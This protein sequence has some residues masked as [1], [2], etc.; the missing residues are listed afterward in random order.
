[1]PLK[2]DDC[3][4]VPDVA[5]A[6]AEQVIPMLPGIIVLNYNYFP[7]RFYSPAKVGATAFAM[8]AIQ[9][10]RQVIFRGVILY[11]RQEG[12]QQPFISTEVRN[13]VLCATISFNFAMETGLLKEA[14]STISKLLVCNDES[15]PMLY[16]Q[17]D[18]LLRYHLDNLPLC[19]I[20]HAPFY[21]DFVHQFSDKSASIAFIQGHYLA[22][23][24]VDAAKVF[25]LCPP[26]H[27]MH[28]TDYPEI[29]HTTLQDVVSSARIL[30]FTAVAH[31]DY[32]KDIDLLLD[33]ALQL[34]QQSHPLTVLI[35]GDDED[36]HGR[37]AKLYGRIPLSYRRSFYIVPKLRKDILYSL[38]KYCRHK[39]I[40]VCP[41]RYETLG[42]TPLESGL[43]GVTTLISNSKQVEARRFFLEKYCFLRTAKDLAT[44]I[45]CFE[46]ADLYQSGKE[47][48]KHLEK[49]ILEGRFKSDFLHA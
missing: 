32:F 36:D 34:Y 11:K 26:I 29:V 22:K 15:P 12:L 27:S 28:I 46:K 17:T 20:H 41:S 37:R 47:L 42:I 31:L 1:M 3:H 43:R 48:Q 9:V 14:I 16:Y 13:S 10:L 21:E 33:T 7:E 30:L 2:Y 49:A 8:S 24:S 35:A 6:R 45:K 19:V 44:V 38:F 39:S 4:P 25:Q 23:S 18:T 40:F 5:V